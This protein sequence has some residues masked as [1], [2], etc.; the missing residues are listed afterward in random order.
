MPEPLK[1]EVEVAAAM[2]GVSL[3]TFFAEAAV[4]RAREVKARHA[5]TVLNDAERDA[6]LKLLAS[7]AEDNPAL[8]R[9]M[10]TEV[11]I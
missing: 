9:L 8:R 1:R 7:P 6:L 2:M 10:Q 3:T 4:E 5:T 11:D